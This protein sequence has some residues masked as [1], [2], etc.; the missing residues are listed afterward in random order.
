[1]CRHRRR[2][3]MKVHGK[4]Q[5]TRRIKC[6]S[7]RASNPRLPEFEMQTARTLI[8]ADANYARHV[9]VVDGED[10]FSFFAHSEEALEPGSESIASFRP[11]FLLYHART[12]INLTTSY[13]P[14]LSSSASDCLILFGER[15]IWVRA[16]YNAIS[17]FFFSS[18]FY[19][20]CTSVNLW[21]DDQRVRLDRFKSILQFSVTVL[22]TPG[23]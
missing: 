10:G 13:K 16:G 14:S 17:R 22:S 1:M 21:R 18:F 12:M 3:R 7:W 23:G 11:R 5:P 19:A 20:H 9:I 8:P 4:F 6:F 15:E 2:Q